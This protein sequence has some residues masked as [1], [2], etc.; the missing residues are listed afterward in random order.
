MMMNMRK[1]ILA[2]LA[3]LLLLPATVSAQNG[4]FRI[5]KWVEIHNAILKELNNSYVDT[6]PLNRMENA[7]AHAM[8]EALDPYT[9]YIPEEEREDMDMVLNKVYGGIGALMVA[10]LILIVMLMVRNKKKKSKA[11]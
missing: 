8:L 9:V 11:K 10:M 4:R 5:G 2:A 7:A 6:L 3:A 1:Y